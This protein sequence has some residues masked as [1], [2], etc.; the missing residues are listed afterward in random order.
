MN[1]WQN[2]IF[3]NWI[4]FMRGNNFNYD[5]SPCDIC[6]CLTFSS[7][8]LLSFFFKVSFFWPSIKNYVILWV[9]NL[10]ISLEQCWVL[11]KNKTPKKWDHRLACYFSLANIT[12]HD[13][14]II[15]KIAPKGLIWEFFF[16]RYFLLVSLPYCYF[17]GLC[18]HGYTRVHH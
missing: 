4:V 18:L 6:R 1:V 15:F 10:G 11:P 7:F 13:E 8:S 2:I 9:L 14:D 16:W 12:L 3:L 17:Q 5:Q